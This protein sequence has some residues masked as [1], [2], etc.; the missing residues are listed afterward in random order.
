MA[1]KQD[2][3][4]YV[5][6]LRMH[7]DQIPEPLLRDFV[8]ARYQCVLV[9]LDGH[10]QPMNRDIEY[11]GDKLVQMAGLM[12]RD[13]N[14]WQYLSNGLRIMEQSEKEATD[15]MR[16]HLGVQSRADLRTNIA[17]RERLNLLHEEFLTWKQE[18][19]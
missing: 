12:C 2:K 9:R 7:P 10:E 19:S 6:N 13:P 8:G 15:W 11:A 17:A 16:D 3:E 14:F 5:L 4:G 1:M 18:K